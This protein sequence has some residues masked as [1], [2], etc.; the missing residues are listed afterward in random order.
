[1]SE[2]G[3]L[4]LS[5]DE[6]YDLQFDDVLW[7]VVWHVRES[8]VPA[9]DDTIRTDAFLGALGG[10][11]ALTRMAALKCGWREGGRERVCE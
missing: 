6:A 8:F 5:L 2:V 11:D 3:I 10:F 7:D 1:M 4:F 9:V